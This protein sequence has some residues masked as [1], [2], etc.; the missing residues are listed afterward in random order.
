M[1]A[2]TILSVF[3]I[4]FICFFYGKLK[5][6]NKNTKEKNAMLSQA[7]NTLQWQ[8]NNLHGYTNQVV[9]GYNTLQWQYKNLNEYTNHVVHE[10]E[11]HKRNQRPW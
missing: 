5:E 9:Q 10:N 1:I 11:S 2:I 4:S 8:Y 7:Y 6:E 3:A